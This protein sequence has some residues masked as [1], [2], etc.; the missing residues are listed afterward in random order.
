MVFAIACAVTIAGSAYAQEPNIQVYFDDMSSAQADCPPVGT[1]WNTEFT[2]LWVVANNF[3]MYVAA[4]EFMIDYPPQLTWLG[5]IYNT[6]TVIGNSASGVS[7]AWT[8]PLDAFD[9]AV[10]MQ[11]TCA[12]ACDGCAGNENTPVDVVPNPN[13]GLLRALRW[14][15]N[16]SF[17]VVGMRSLICATVPVEETTWG[18]IKSLYN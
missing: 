13:Q 10:L 11:A 7:L 18:Q 14:P 8:I 5:D 1:P 17:D 4:V 15:D 6:D 16:V 3:D 9:R 12:W 2:T